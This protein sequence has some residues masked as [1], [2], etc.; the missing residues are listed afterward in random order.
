M[1]CR[2]SVPTILIVLTFGLGSCL[3]S[4][5]ANDDWP[6]WRG[7][8]QNGSIAAAGHFGEKP[9]ALT[10]QWKRHLG[11]G[12]SAVSIADGKVIATYANGKDDLLGVLDAKTGR[13]LWTF[14]LGKMYKAHD[15]GHDGPVSTPVV[16][17]K[18]VFVLGADGFLGA[19]DL[20][21]GEKIWSLQLATTFD[22]HVP[23]WGFTTTPVIVDDLLIVQVGGRANSGTVA[24]D[25]RNG[26]V[27]WK[28]ESGTIDY[29]SP[30]V[31]S[32]HGRRQVVASSSSGTVGID[33]STGK[34]LWK[35]SQST[36]ND[37][38]PLPVGNDRLL[39]RG[40]SGSWLY[41][42]RE[43]G[44]PTQVWR[45]SELRGNYDTPVL[46]RESLF[47]FT[48]NTLTCLDLKTGQRHWRSR[49][50]G[51]KGIILVDGHLVIFGSKGDVVVA[52]ASSRRY[53]E[54]ARLNVSD[55]DGYASPSFADGTIFARNLQG[56]LFAVGT[57]AQ[58]SVASDKPTPPSTRFA[59]FVKKLEAAADKTAELDRFM[60]SQSSFPIVED[61]RWVHFVYRG[62]A[63]DVGISGTMIAQG[64]ED[65][66]HRVPETDFFHRTYA[67]EPGSR[68]E[69]Q[70]HVDFDTTVPDPRNP[71]RAADRRRT[72]ELVTQGWSEPK[73]IST[74]E[75]KQ[76][77]SM[78]AVRIGNRR[79]EVYLPHGYLDSDKKYPLVVVTDGQAW[80]GSGRLTNVVNQLSE[81][82]IE[83]PIVAFV[84]GGRSRELGG[85]GTRGYAQHLAREVTRAIHGRY[86]TRGTPESTTL[87][88]KRGAAVAAVY[89]TLAYPDVFGQCIAISY[90]RADTV[91]R[92]LISAEMRDEFKSKPRFHLSWNRYDVWRPQ[93]FDCRQQSKALFDELESN[94]F[95][96]K[97]G[98]RNDSSS[99]R[100]W[101][102]LA[103]QS[104]SQMLSK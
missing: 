13:E 21:S 6:R 45:S 7:P 30:V 62:Q 14:R 100:S 91:R 60:K 19:L 28:Q 89:A 70:F 23:F 53:R 73:F 42:I 41:G 29:R 12:Y 34:V 102:I 80:S 17:E 76:S 65:A 94:G 37:T 40:R 15:G 55:A 26:K 35:I 66:L 8:N 86:R 88:G 59:S 43:S 99:W 31:A 49:Q 56:D 83:A 64:E 39:L 93:S 77:G 9:F 68:W 87:M 1:N 63:S 50:P 18:T 79:V 3:N 20:D 85:A 36:G 57:I 92:D 54:K 51:G 61:D 47:G 82:S 71:N 69:Y 4:V 78:E 25:K 16:D 90:G 84:S 72:S 46:F 101:R 27:R 75:G 38:T 22:A 67:I 10:L 48:D 52:E 33:P 98:E 74:Y 5:A 104:L 11:A 44:N 2:L 95:S 81:S 97:G 96:V 58:P 32:F 103:G 24:F